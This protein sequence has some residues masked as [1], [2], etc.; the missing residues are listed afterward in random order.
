MHGLKK[1]F[2]TQ[3]SGNGSFGYLKDVVYKKTP[4]KPIQ[5]AQFLLKGKGFKG[6]CVF[7]LLN[8]FWTPK[9]W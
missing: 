9:T 6:K 7:L 1:N 8:M 3:T 4:V 5:I 2:Q